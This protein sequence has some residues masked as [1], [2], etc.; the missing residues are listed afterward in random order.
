MMNSGFDRRD[1]LRV[2][3][4]DVWRDQLARDGVGGGYLLSLP[5]AASRR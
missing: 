1:F 3:G 2:D 5:R 4:V